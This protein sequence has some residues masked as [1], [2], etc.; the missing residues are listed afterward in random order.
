MQKV[1][2]FDT[3]DF[4]NVGGAEKE[5]YVLMNGFNKLDE[6]PSAQV[7][8]KGYVHD[9]AKSST[10]TGYEGSFSFESDRIAD[11]KANKFLFEIGYYQ[12]TGI[13]AETDYI[14]VDL[15][16]KEAESAENEFPARKF[17]VAVEIS[18]IAGEPQEVQ[19]V[20]GTLHQCG[21]F[22]LGTFNTETKKFTPKPDAAA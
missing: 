18:D 1:M 11:D 20:S 19:T 2:R 9:K 17:R 14:R 21:D 22:V 15:S 4:L 3:L 7:D 8:T 12:K 5:E 10:I 6:S 13:D 16:M